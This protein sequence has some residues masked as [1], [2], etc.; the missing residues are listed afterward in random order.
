M[1]SRTAGSLNDTGPRDE[2]KQTVRTV[3]VV[4]VLISLSGAAAE[5]ADAQPSGDPQTM[6]SDSPLL[7]PWSGPYGGVPPWDAVRVGEFEPAF[8]RA[9]AIATREIDVIASDPEPPTF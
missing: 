4:A 1:K 3:A 7:A 9:I 6:T 2:R 8:D 5:P